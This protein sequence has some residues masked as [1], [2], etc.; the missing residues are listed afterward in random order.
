[1]A[2][3]TSPRILLLEDL[4]LYVR[5]PSR[6]FEGAEGGFYLERLNSGSEVRAMRNKSQHRMGRAGSEAQV[7]EAKLG[8]IRCNVLSGPAE[9]RGVPLIWRN[10]AGHHR[11]PQTRPTPIYPFASLELLQGFLG[12]PH[13]LVAMISG[14]ELGQQAPGKFPGL[15]M[16]TSPA[17]VC[18]GVQDSLLVSLHVLWGRL[19]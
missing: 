14:D 6:D 17:P 10:Q 16:I 4:K 7:G 11:F 2:E 1:M 5:G 13:W 12:S 18:V 3:I 8:T 9:A 15:Y 19:E